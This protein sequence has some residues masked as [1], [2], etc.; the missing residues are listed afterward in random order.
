MSYEVSFLYSLVVTLV[1]E[2]T[3]VYIFGK[4]FYN[5]KDKLGIVFAGIISSALTLPYFWF[6][7]PAFIANRVMYITTGEVA[8]IIVEAFIYFRLLKLKFRQAL[9][10]SIIANLVSVLVGLLIIWLMGL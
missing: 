5:N 6:I 1:V 7:L 2:V 9:F 10:V 8:I 4:Y 3:V